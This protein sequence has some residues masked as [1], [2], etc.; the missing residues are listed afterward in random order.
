VPVII[1]K[2][3]KGLSREQK[4]RIVKEF[5]DTMVSVAGVKKE[6]VTIMIEEKELEDIG[7]GGKLRCD[8]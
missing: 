2:Q 7:K 4:R 5:T 8:P 1:L 6:L 3:K